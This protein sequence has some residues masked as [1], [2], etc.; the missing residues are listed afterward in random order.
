MAGPAD[1][2]AVPV[3]DTPPAA[4]PAA[5]GPE[6][7]GAVPVAE[8]PGVAS[9]IMH[10]AAPAVERGIMAALTAAPTVADLAVRGINYGLS[11]LSPTYAGDLA[12]IEEL[13]KANSSL[14][15]P[16]Y[17][18]MQ[19]QVEKLTGPMYEAKTPVGKV[20]QTA[21]EMAPTIA[22]GGGTLAQKGAQLAGAVGGGKVGEFLG[23]MV[24]HGTAGSV[25]G[26]LLGSGLPKAITPFPQP[27]ARYAK[28]VATLTDAGVPL[29]AGR[30]TGSPG[31]QKIE[32][33]LGPKGDEAADFTKAATKVTGSSASNPQDIVN[34]PKGGQGNALA[35]EQQRLTQGFDNVFSKS[36]QIPYGNLSSD[37]QGIV[38]GY[39]ATAGASADPKIDEL[40]NLIVL[41]KSGRPMANAQVAGMDGARYQFIKD[42]LEAA[43]AGSTGTEKQAAMAM[44]KS[45]EDTLR[46]SMSPQE[47]QAFDALNRQYSNYK[48]VAGAAQGPGGTITPEALRTSAVSRAGTE[49]FNLGKAGEAGDLARAGVNV[50]GKRPTF[51]SEH[52][53]TAL[54]TLIGGGAGI[55][56]FI[57][58]AP[59]ETALSTSILGS[60]IGTSAGHLASTV[61]KP[62]ARAAYYNPMVQALL[63]NQVMGKGGADPGLMTMLLANPSVTP[64]IP[65]APK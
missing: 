40:A 6:A 63:G 54:G 20:A 52:T 57:M 2:G 26:T 34:L 30:K 35:A 60:I 61:G 29:T 17:S 42:K 37:V 19:P 3:P 22:T 58:G 4:T 31:L 21:I 8:T 28:D 47:Q 51:N 65:Q 25:I 49:G 43:I 39:K 10:A 48:T 44:K 55:P 16:T 32:S 27:N 23:N 36:T 33:A 11:K 59:A 45:M 12:K 14:P 62:A 56:A 38:R 18:D 64:S 15:M 13:R 46:G 53:T 5:S 24:G 1:W 7:W 9:D 41:G 50:M